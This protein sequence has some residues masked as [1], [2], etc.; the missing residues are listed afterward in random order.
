MIAP[1]S[2]PKS[3]SSRRVGGAAF[4]I[5]REL[6]AP[7]IVG[8]AGGLR[9]AGQNKIF[10]HQVVHRGA[11]ETSIG[12]SGSAYDRLAADVERRIDDDGASRELV[13][14]ADNRM[15]ARVSLAMDGLD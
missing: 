9:R 2:K 11:H 13:K 14:A 4:S 12:V 8:L 6:R 7:R 15:E 1:S 5:K 10:D 3:R